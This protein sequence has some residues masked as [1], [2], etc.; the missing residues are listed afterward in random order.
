VRSVALAGAL[1]AALL[2]AAPADAATR[3]KRYT[4]WDADGDPAVSRYFHGSAECTRASQ[5]NERREAWRCTSGNVT[6]DPCFKSPTDDEVLCVDSPWARLGYLLTAVI[7][8]SDHGSSPAQGPWALQVGK[9]RCTFIRR[10]ARRRASYRCGRGKRGP[11]L[12]GRPNT[13]RSTWTIR[14]ARS[15]RGRGARRVRVREAWL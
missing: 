9:R 4:P 2:L 1:L 14:A 5:Y 8:E 7:D 11:F 6:L 12:F 3:V 15:R 10:P 13:R